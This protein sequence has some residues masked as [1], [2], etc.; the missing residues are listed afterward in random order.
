MPD[1]RSP[2]LVVAGTVAVAV[3]LAVA[4]LLA[5]P[6]GT[7]LSAQVARAGFFDRYGFAPLDFG[8]YGGVSPY[9]YSLISPPMMS[10]LGPR[11]T[12]ALAAVVSA[13]ALVLLFLRT[14]ARRPLLGGVLGAVCVVGNLVSGRVT[15]AVGVAFG[16][17]AL[18]AL[19]S[20]RPWLRGPGAV[21]AAALAAAASPVAGL[22]T[23]LAGVA[24]ALS[25]RSRWRGGAAVA[26]GA[27]VP[28]AVMALL[29][30]D[31]GWM[32]ISALDALRAGTVSL[33]VALLVP[34]R[35]VRVGA[36]LSALG[37]AAAFALHT[38]V[39]LNATRLAAMFALPLLAAY[40]RL[41]T[42]LAGARRRAALLAAVLLLVAVWQP[43]VSRTDLAAAGDPTAARGY[44]QPL[45]DELAR[46]P[47]GRVEVVPTANY[48][49]A[50]YVP[51]VAPLARGWLRQ[52]D[53]ARNGLFFDGTLDARS[54]AT[55][56]HGNGV[57]YVAVAAARPS[58]VG[59]REA[60][61]IGG[62]LPYL[63]EVWH[64]PR[65]RLYAV[66]D[67]TPVVGSPGRLVEVDAGGVTFTA[68]RPG[69][70]LVRVRWSRWL[71]VDGAGA[72]LAPAAQGWTT[73]RVTRPGRHVLSGRL[74]PGPRCGKVR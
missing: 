33:A 62:G 69:D 58:W 4:F 29:F 32:N 68:D 35:P 2:R 3:A 13:V 14:G 40:G 17:L 70:V 44:F 74:W 21:A 39:G 25:D 59:R 46:R 52:L 9:G 30:G 56:L 54:Y 10:L 27:A 15:Y 31:G 53:L 24:L 16:L 26:A 23:G 34:R 49:E 20:A 42:R 41:P 36:L 65:W 5:P 22:F 11:V 43:P 37:V 50:A 48:W 51:Q 8:W 72:C 28:L 19:T 18:L 47:A 64:D 66:V 60:E 73:V 71:A 7:D 45:L 61:L 12:G 55:W 38:P 6:M 1:R 57:A 67:P 63:R